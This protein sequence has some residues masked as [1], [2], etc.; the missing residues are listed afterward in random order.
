VLR[1]RLYRHFIRL[2]QLDT[3]LKRM[4]PDKYLWTPGTTL[5][6]RPQWV[7]FAIFMGQRRGCLVGTNTFRHGPHSKWVSMGQKSVT[8]KNILTSSDI[9]TPSYVQKS[10]PKNLT[11]PPPWRKG[12][13]AFKSLR[14]LA[15]YS[16]FPEKYT[17]YWEILQRP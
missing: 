17:G 9:P 6:K 7:N 14:F 15:L 4:R 11:F 12:V 8:K 3:F 2:E 16:K 5:P 13:H 1:R 10:P